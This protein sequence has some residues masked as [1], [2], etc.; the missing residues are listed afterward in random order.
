MSVVVV[1][2][3]H[4]TPE[5]RADVVA[6]FEETIAEVHANDAGCELYAMHEDTDTLVMIEKWT[7]AEDLES[8]RVS[9]TMK[10]LD[11]KLAGKLTDKTVVK[12]YQPHPAGKPEQG[13]L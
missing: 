5:H 11:P 4:P 7:S 3:I 2:T 1:A 12:I 13:A 8:H 10:S 9:E 6:L